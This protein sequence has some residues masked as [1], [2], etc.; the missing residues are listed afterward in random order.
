MLQY[1]TVFIFDSNGNSIIQATID[2]K[3]FE[4]SSSL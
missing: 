1:I 2:V 4:L 3:S